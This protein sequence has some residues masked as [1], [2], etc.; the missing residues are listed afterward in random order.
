MGQPGGRGWLGPSGKALRRLKS[1]ARVEA[2]KDGLHRQQGAGQRGAPSDKRRKVHE[3]SIP[4]RPAS[5][6]QQLLPSNLR[7]RARWT[8]APRSASLRAR[9]VRAEGKGEAPYD[10]Q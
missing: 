10:V 2:E 4:D 8:D 7:N 9:G 3:G 1:L 6:R 5:R